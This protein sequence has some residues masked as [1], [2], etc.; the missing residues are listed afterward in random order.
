MENHSRR[1]R[2][3]S[4][5]RWQEFQQTLKTSSHSEDAQDVECLADV[6]PRCNRSEKMAGIACCKSYLVVHRPCIGENCDIKH[7]GTEKM[8]QMLSVLPLPCLV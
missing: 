7:Y 2:D 4:I 3:F 1:T 6:M 8:R 5:T